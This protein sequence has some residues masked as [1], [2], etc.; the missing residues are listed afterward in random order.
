M[1]RTYYRTAA[2]VMIIAL[3]RLTFAQDGLKDAKE[4]EAFLDGVVITTM[5]ASHIPGAVVVVVK[6]GELFFSKG[7]GFADKAKKSPVLPDATLFR[8]ASVS[9]LFTATAVMQ[10]YEE[11]KVKLDEDVNVY[12]KGYQLPNAFPGPV[13]LMNLMTHTGGFDERSIGMMVKS[14]GDMPALR[15]YLSERMPVRVRPAG[16]IAAY[17]NAGVALQGLVVESV[18]GM[19]FNDYVK[20]HIYDPLGMT[21]SSFDVTAE[22]LPRLATGYK[23]AGE[24]KAVDPYWL[25]DAPAG[26]MVTT[27]LDISKFMIAQLQLGKLGDA[28]ILTEETARKMQERQHSADPRIDGIACQFWEQHINGLRTISHGGDLL[29][30]AS[31][32]MLVPE[33]NIGLFV[34]C[35]NDVNE[36]RANLSKQFMNRYY[37]AAATPEKPAVAAD[38]KTRVAGYAGSY[39]PSRYAENSVE[40]LTILLSQPKVVPGKEDGTIVLIGER[41]AT[42][43]EVQPGLFYSTENPNNYVFFETRTDGS[44]DRAYLGFFA[45]ER[46]KWYEQTMIQLAWIVFMI[47]TFGS[48]VIVWPIVWLVRRLKGTATRSGATALGA[49]VLAFAI[50]AASIF[51]LV[52]MMVIL[53]SEVDELSYG[54]PRDMIALLSIPFATIPMTIIFAV[55]LVPVFM[56]RA[57]TRL[58]RIHASVVALSAISM[59]PFLWM[60]NLIGYHW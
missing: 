58:E 30:F 14:A 51:M 41:P 54:M 29:G 18:S 23:F 59:V 48:A 56:R 57:W 31:L 47:L 25:K 19:S 17:S 39:R 10:L 44:A 5:D 22:M 52:T 49:R 21:N 45:L 33:K 46:V 55:L 11:G 20:Q 42:F 13:T 2:L 38:F 43:F 28:R 7:Y 1:Y 3:G 26:S 50:S 6:D 27:G 36:L 35:N 12:L 9:K 16:D 15:T 40:K 34:S 24:Y 37:P 4:L 8:I 60:W 53:S 32:L